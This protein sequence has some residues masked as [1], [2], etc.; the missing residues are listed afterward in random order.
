MSDEE[1]E[2]YDGPSPEA[3]DVACAICGVYGCPGTCAPQE[4]EDEIRATEYLL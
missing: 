4:D 3:G 1:N 2:E